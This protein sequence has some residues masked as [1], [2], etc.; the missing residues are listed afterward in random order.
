MTIKQLTML[1][2]ACAFGGAGS[3]PSARAADPAAVEVQITKLKNSTGSVVVCLWK[4]G[5]IDGFPN[6][7]KGKPMAI[8]TAPANAPKVVFTNVEPGSYAISF[9]HDEKGTGIPE[10]NLVGMPKNAIGLSNN[11]AVGITSPPTFVKAQF[12]V[13]A[14]VRHTIEARYLF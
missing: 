5:S 9:F 11:P 1:V 8:L 2:L 13:P 12:A 7:H 14:I 10:T 6:C 4:E 3:I